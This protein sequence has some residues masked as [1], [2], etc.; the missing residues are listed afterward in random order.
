MALTGAEAEL[1]DANDVCNTALRN[2][3]AA[4][5]RAD[6]EL[7]VLRQA[8]LEHE[9]AVQRLARMLSKG[10]G[11][12]RSADYDTP[13]TSSNAHPALPAPPR[14]AGPRAPP[15]G[16]PVSATRAELAAHGVLLES[17]ASESLAEGLLHALRQR[18]QSP[19]AASVSP[20]RAAAAAAPVRTEASATV[21]LIGFGKSH[22]LGHSDDTL[23]AVPTEP[24]VLAQTLRS[25]TPVAIACSELHALLVTTRNGGEGGDVFSWGRDSG[26]RLGGGTEAVSP[27]VLVTVPRPVAG[28]QGVTVT[29]VACSVNHSVAVSIDGE[30]Y[31]W[32]SAERGLLGLP[33]ELV[34]QLPSDPESN[35]PYSPRAVKVHA[36]AS[37][38]P[39]P[40]SL[41][42]HPPPL[43]PHPW[44]VARDP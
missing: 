25:N 42:P 43:T 23:L 1:V 32:G 30:L 3:K 20:S 5:E 21:R 31:A 15:D 44:P 41:S 38:N 33:Q 39:R 11:F 18:L 8:E 7:L 16:T 40:S 36:S 27:G 37:P 34:A 35:E 2:M 12:C 14:S 13:S 9:S 6:S 26:G 17:D 29:R 22:V 28:L 19:S 24:S 4:E 10:D